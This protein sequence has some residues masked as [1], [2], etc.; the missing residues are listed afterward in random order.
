[1]CMY[2]AYVH[3]HVQMYAYKYS[4][5][6]THDYA[7][8]RRHSHGCM[9]VQLYM[10]GIQCMYVVQMETSK[11]S[12]PGLSLGICERNRVVL[13]PRGWSLSDV[14]R[15]ART[16][17]LAEH[18]LAMLL[19]LMCVCVCMYVCGM[20]CVFLACGVCCV[21]MCVRLFVYVCIHWRSR[22]HKS[23]WLKYRAPCMPTARP[24][25]ALS[26]C[27]IFPCKSTAKG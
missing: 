3:V 24:P 10:Q 18:N 5:T 21:R 23:L 1:M 2:G 26:R 9:H 19:A 25:W 6:H 14:Y 12:S 17:L 8:M 15:S 13:C 4:F 11:I 16:S 7:H 22:L 20:V 27:R